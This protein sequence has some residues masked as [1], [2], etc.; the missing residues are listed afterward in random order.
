[1]LFGL[2]LLSFNGKSDSILILEE[3]GFIVSVEDV[4]LDGDKDPEFQDS[5]ACSFKFSILGELNLLINSISALLGESRSVFVEFKPLVL[6]VE[7]LVLLI[8]LF[9]LLFVEPLDPAPPP[10]DHQEKIKSIIK[11]TLVFISSK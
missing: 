6:I 8:G 2:K 11:F 7:E 5:L 10:P 9:V 4:E 1:L 3:D